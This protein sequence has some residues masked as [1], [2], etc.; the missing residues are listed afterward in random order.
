MS[1]ADWTS[2]SSGGSY[3][4]I[5]DGTAPSPPDIMNIIA[6]SQD[7]QNITAGTFKDS[8]I[9]AW[10]KQTSAN[11]HTLRLVLRSQNTTFQGN[12]AKYFLTT[13]TA[14]DATDVSVTQEVWVNGVVT[15]L[16]NGLIA[17][18]NGN[19]LNSWQ[20]YQFSAFNDGTDILLRTAQW[21]G[22]AF[23]PIVDSAAPIATFPTL[24]AVGSCRFGGTVTAANMA[25]DDVS[26]YSLT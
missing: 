8:R 2:I 6:G 7:F 4:I 22:G 11:A 18:L 26:F 19:P 24:D 5:A 14:F 15:T 10:T 9:T 17:S 12:P 23:V 16:F 1:S 13:L 21:D 3:S 25:I 20:L